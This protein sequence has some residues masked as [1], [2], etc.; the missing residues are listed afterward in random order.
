MS[1]STG[2]PAA[3]PRVRDRAREAITLM[4]FSGGVSVGVTLLLLLAYGLGR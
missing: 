2:A 3:V 4:A 1:M